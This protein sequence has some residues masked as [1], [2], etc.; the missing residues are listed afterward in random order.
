[1][2]QSFDIRVL[3]YWH[4]KHPDVRLALLIE[5]L[6]TINENLTELGFVPDVYSPEFHLLDK[7]EIIFLHGKIPTREV[8]TGKKQTKLRVIPWTVNEEIDMKELKEMNV[9]GIITDYPDRARKLKLTLNG[10][11]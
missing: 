11:K 9:D 6:K 4:T 5:N 8:K 10:K 1:M 7:N 2:I 3:K